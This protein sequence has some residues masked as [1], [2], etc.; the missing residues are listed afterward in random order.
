MYWPIDSIFWSLGTAV[1]QVFVHNSLR[2]GCLYSH[3]VSYAECLACAEHSSSNKMIYT[4]LWR[5]DIRDSSTDVDRFDE[6]K[7]PTEELWWLMRWRIWYLSHIYPD[8]HTSPHTYTQFVYL[9]VLTVDAFLL[10]RL[11][12]TQYAICPILRDYERVDTLVGNPRKSSSVLQVA[13]T[14]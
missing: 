2:H 11:L 3:A 8:I 5:T 4:K 13:S 6:C 12:D 10:Y 1:L 14:N 9:C 7:Q